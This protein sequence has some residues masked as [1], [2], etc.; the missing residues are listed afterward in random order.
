M[1]KQRDPQDD[2]ERHAGAAGGALELLS[3]RTTRAAAP[4][5]TRGTPVQPVTVLR[6]KISAAL[7]CLALLIKSGR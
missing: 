6:K 7:F 3:T 5:V 2:R 4:C 1:R